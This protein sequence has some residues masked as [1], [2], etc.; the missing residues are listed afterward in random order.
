[1]RARRERFLARAAGTYALARNIPGAPENARVARVEARRDQ[2]TNP[3]SIADTE[4]GHVI[5]VVAA[6]H[7]PACG[8][9]PGT[10]ERARKFRRRKRAVFPA[11][12]RALR[13]AS[14][15]NA[16]GIS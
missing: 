15:L 3:H 7:W 8:V 5:V 6:P 2:S 16:V 13:P 4:F 11:A 1:L 12:L 14:S 9:R 10:G